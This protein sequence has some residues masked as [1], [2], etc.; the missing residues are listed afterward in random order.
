MAR[1]ADTNVI[2]RLIARDDARQVEQALAQAR[3]GL[4]VSHVVLVEVTWVLS[5]V[6]DLAT[7]QIANAMELLLDHPDLT[8]EGPDVVRAALAQF[9]GRRGVDFSDCLIVEIARKAGQAPLLTF[10]R[11]SAKLDGA[12]LIR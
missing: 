6:Y 12:E 5:S 11:A 3:A 8:V 4:W 2:V 10:D 7:D 9:D 1:A